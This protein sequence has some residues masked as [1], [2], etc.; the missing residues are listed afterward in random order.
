MHDHYSNQGKWPRLFENLKEKGSLRAIW[1]RTPH[2][3]LKMMNESW[4]EIE[5]EAVERNQWR[6][7]FA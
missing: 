3:G 2:E 5:K 1:H 7:L 4:D 6:M